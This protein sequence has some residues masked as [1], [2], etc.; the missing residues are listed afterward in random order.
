M[1]TEQEIREVLNETIAEK[2]GIRTP[3]V[4][5]I[6]ILR[7]NVLSGVIEALE[8]VLNDKEADDKQP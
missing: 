8:W 5:Q 2:E 7:F 6:D 4:N 1:R 3:I